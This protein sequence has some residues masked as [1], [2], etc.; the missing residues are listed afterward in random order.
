MGTKKKLIFCLIMVVLFVGTVFFGSVVETGDGDR[1]NNSTQS[2]EQ[3]VSDVGTEQ[4]TESVNYPTTE[5]STVVDITTTEEPDTFAEDTY[6]IDQQTYDEL[7]AMVDS[8]SVEEKVGQM[9]FVKNDGRFGAS[10]L[11]EYPIGGMILF[12]G[13]IKGKSV[14]MLD[15]YLTSFK[16]ATKVPMLIGTDEE[17]G[18][19]IRLSKYPTFVDEPYKSPKLLYEEGGY[20]AI[21]ADTISKCQ[22]LLGYDINVNFAPVCDISTTPGEY[23]Y[24][25]TFGETVEE[26]CTYV[27]LVVAAMKQENMGSVLKHFPGYGGN[28]DTHTSVIHDQRPYEEFQ[29]ADLLPFK[30]GIDAGADCVLVSHNVV[31]CMDAQWP[32]SLSEEVHRILRE[33]LGFK[34]VIITDDLMMSGVSSYLSDEESAVKAVLAG[35]DMILSTNYTVQ[36]QAVLDAVNSG[37]ISE[38]IIDESVLRV[39]I[40]KRNLGIL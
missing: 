17:G 6:G 24:Q 18:S 11:E 1:G 37:E 31:E 5:A 3:V 15:E 2:T 19:V 22:T 16:N 13:D 25:R 38:D 33:E 14:V 30:A 10:V 20:D 39:L 40:W 23:M 28:G 35:N 29:N 12:A 21:E 9:F 34:G 4:I 26:T 32:A 36:Y 27:E 8:M 7:I